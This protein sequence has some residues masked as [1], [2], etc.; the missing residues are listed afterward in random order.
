MRGDIAICI[1]TRNRRSALDKCAAQ[2]TKHR[3]EGASYFFVNDAGEPTP[4]DDYR[5]SERVGIPRAKNMCLQLAMD[6]GAA[7]VFLFDDDCYP[8]RDNWHLPYIQSGL[9]HLCFTFTTGYDGMGAWPNGTVSGCGR[10]VYHVLG[11]GCMLYF[12]RHCIETVGG[13]DTGFGLGKYEHADLSRRV[14][15]AGLTPNKFIDVVGSDKLLHS[16]D[17]AGE[18]TR[19][20]TK[21][22]QAQ[23]MAAGSDRFWAN[24]G[25]KSYKEYRS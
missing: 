6:A 14:F 2:H 8:I 20:F 24:E 11:C 15:N 4:Y 13:F 25:D 5:F 19:T 10:F 16:M 21:E 22:E 23:L 18:V 1:T 9:H 3:V 12:T 17:Q 7:H